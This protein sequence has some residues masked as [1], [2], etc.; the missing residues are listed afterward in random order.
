ME[1]AYSP[2]HTLLP[3]LLVITA[4]RQSF[5]LF[6]CRAYIGNNKSRYFSALALQK[7]RKF[8][9]PVLGHSHG[10]TITSS[11]DVRYSVRAR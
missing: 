11:S 4:L 2:L 7:L 1:H 6:I 8:V 10:D 5:F 9:A 3:S